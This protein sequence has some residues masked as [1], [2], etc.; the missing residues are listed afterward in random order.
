MLETVL[1]DLDKALQDSAAQFAGT[2]AVLAV[3][4]ER[5]APIRG[6]VWGARQGT[7]GSVIPLQLGKGD[8]A[9]MVVSD[10]FSGRSQ[11]EGDK[12]WYALMLCSA[13]NGDCLAHT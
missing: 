4:G 10:E 2:S 9:K 11:E 13:Y 6:R 7:A 5:G 3:R 12:L 1:R 8:A